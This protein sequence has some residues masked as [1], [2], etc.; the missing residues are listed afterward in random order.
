MAES[1]KSIEEIVLELKRGQ[2]REHNA[3]LLFK[4]YYHRACRFFRSKG[5]PPEDCEELAEDVFVSVYNKL[6]ELRHETKF[7]NWVF[8]IAMNVYLN[9]LERRRA[10]K[11]AA[12]MVPLGGESTDPQDVGALTAAGGDP[13]TEVLESE[14]LQVVR[15]AVHELPPQMRSCVFLRVDDGLSYREIATV[16]GISVNTVSAHLHQA[17]SLLKERLGR[18]FGEI[19][20]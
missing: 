13:E 7:E 3:R 11:R 16:M 19:E 14:K 6:D 15:G 5:L 9:D 17:R 4:Y 18:Y 20:M 2:D 1:P 12:T 8:K 10:G